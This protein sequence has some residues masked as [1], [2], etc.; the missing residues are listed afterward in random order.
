MSYVDFDNLH[1]PSGR[2]TIINGELCL[3]RTNDQFSDI[4][5]KDKYPK[6][7]LWYE[8]NNYSI[9]MIKSI[10]WMISVICKESKRDFDTYKRLFKQYKQKSERN[11]TYLLECLMFDLFDEYPRGTKFQINN[12]YH[13]LSRQYQELVDN[14]III[15]RNNR[16][17]NSTLNAEAGSLAT[18]LCYLQNCKIFTIKQLNEKVIGEYLVYANVGIPILKRIGKILECYYESIN[19]VDGLS[20]CK[21]FPDNG[22]RNKAFLGLTK[23]EEEKLEG[24]LLDDNSPISKRDRAVGR[25]FYYTGIRSSECRLFKKEDI[26]WVKKCITIHQIKTNKEIIL[27]LRPVVG[28][29]ILDYLQNERPNVKSD[30]VFISD[31]KQ[32]NSGLEINPYR[33]VEEIYKKCGIRNGKARKGAHILRHD[34]ASRMSDSGS[35]LFVIQS[36]LGHSRADTTAQYITTSINQLR[37]CALSIERFPIKHILYKKK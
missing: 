6:L 8:E 23:E 5:L 4:P 16:K 31:R 34:L 26:D 13:K 35:D 33:I 11:L 36:T 24:F 30:L 32:A 7:I 21:L 18:F 3:K 9:Q 22:N 15:G 28:N 37:L 19:D 20:I 10:R 1:H 29:A 14:C 25:L 12:A 2:L 17:S 27:P